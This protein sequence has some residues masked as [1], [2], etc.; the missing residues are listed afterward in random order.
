[1]PRSARSD[2]HGAFRLHL[3]AAR[4]YLAER[5]EPTK[6]AD[7]AQHACLHC[8][9]P[10]TGKLEPWP[11]RHSRTT[12]GELALPMTM[13]VSSLEHLLYLA[14]AGRGITCLPDFSIK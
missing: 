13:V 4:G 11:V 6:P 8:R 10:T 14:Q 2:R 1:M 3:V 5:G 12:A 9:Y 7:L